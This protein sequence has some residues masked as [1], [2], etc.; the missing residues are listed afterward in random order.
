LPNRGRAGSRAR[1]ID[2][3]EAGKWQFAHNRVF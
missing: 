3:S 1:E 2:H